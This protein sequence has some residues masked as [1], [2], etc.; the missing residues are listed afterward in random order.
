MPTIKRTPRWEEYLHTP[1]LVELH[2]LVSYVKAI[3]ESAKE[4][5]ADARKQIARLKDIAQQRH[6][7]EQEKLARKAGD[8]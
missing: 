2:S 4:S 5:T 8:T 1:E 7:R 3:K 6:R